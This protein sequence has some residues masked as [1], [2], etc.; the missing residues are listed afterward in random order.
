MDIHFY[1]HLNSTKSFRDLSR[2]QFYTPLPKDWC[3]A[4][5]D[6]RN[7]T[8]LVKKGRYRDINLIG[9]S[10][11]AALSNRISGTELPFSFSGDGSIIA[12]PGVYRKEA[13]QIVRGCRNLAKRS[14]NLNLAAG[15][16]PVT[17]LY[18]SGH[19]LLVAKFQTSKHVTQAS[20]MGSGLSEAENRIKTRSGKITD[21]HSA[22]AVDLSGLECRWNPF[23]AD[24]LAISLIV[25]ATGDSLE[26]QFNTYRQLLDAIRHL[27]GD[28]FQS[29]P[30]LEKNMKLS[31]RFETLWAEAKLKS[32]GGHLKRCYYLCKL[33]LLQLTGKFFM[34]FNI[35]T[36]QTNW[37]DYKPDFIQNSDYRKF[38]QNLKMIITGD[39]TMKKE[40]IDVL[41][42]LYK[43][44][45]IIYGL[46]E[47]SSTV[48]TC[49]V[50]E[51]QNNH[52]HFVD[53]AGGGYTKAS[54]DYKKRAK[55]FNKRKI[56]PVESEFLNSGR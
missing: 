56:D 2:Y 41:N 54:I 7:S 50:K 25:G 12:F 27:S 5:S 23:P 8:N 26:E 40:L 13:E 55:K 21:Q 45:K 29:K 14:F 11:I 30:I 20:F 4:V 32:R 44:N 39:R 31:F 49:F 28:R 24:E 17:E 33:I 6:V 9:A 38:N 43:E 47:T 10:V 37:G 53:G 34:R 3:I 19:S 15:I 1:K 16:I 18:S 52:I 48:S 36:S 51:Y 42:R 22:R 46:H 35:S